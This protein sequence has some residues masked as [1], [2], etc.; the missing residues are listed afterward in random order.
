M[1]FK[2]LKQALGKVWLIEEM[3][4]RHYEELLFQIL[5]G[6]ATITAGLFDDIEMP[7]RANSSGISTSNGEVL[8][9]P[10][11]GIMMQDDFCGMMGTDSMSKMLKAV[12]RDN[13]I[14]SIVLK[15]RTPGGS[16]DGTENFS[17]T[18]KASNKPVVTWAEKMCSAGYWV[19]SASSEIIISG[20]TA[21]VGSIGTMASLR[22][23]RAQDEKSG[24]KELVFFASRS[25]HK[26]R[27]SL[28][29]LDGKPEAYIKEFL[30]PLNDAFENTVIRNRA[31]KID[32]KKEDVLTGKVYIGSKA[33]KDGLADNIGSLDY[34]IKR[35]LQLAK[36]IRK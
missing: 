29:A 17:N 11:Q 27:A 10:V 13:S 32:L 36:T 20:E 35:S 5:E 8:V 21:M 4:A 18:V 2:I 14:Q 16:V 12:Y 23:T 22:D 9:L 33:I 31:G 7:Y 26:N 19:G 30:D 6:K 34:A 1:D 24:R 25:I 15:M 28:E 3:G